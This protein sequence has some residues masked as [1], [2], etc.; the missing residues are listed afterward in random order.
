MDS[1]QII[2]N[3]KFRAAD[4]A[5]GDARQ[6]SNFDASK[7]EQILLQNRGFKTKN[8]Q[9]EFLNPDLSKITTKSLGIDKKAIEKTL[10]RIKEAI[11][12][13][14]QI[15]IYGDYDVDG[16]CATA[17][18]WETLRGVSANVMPY[19]PHRVKHGYGLT[20]KGISDMLLRFPNTKLLFTVDNGIVAYE[21]SKYAKEKAID[22]VITDH[23]L[24]SSE[25]PDVF[26]IVH[27]TQVCGTGVAYFLAQGIK[28]K[29]G[30]TKRDDHLELVALATVAD[31][32]PLVGPNRA[33][34]KEGLIEIH[35][36]KRVGLLE[37]FEE[38]Q[39]KKEEIGTYE[40]GHIIAPRINAMGRIGDAMD[41]LRLICTNNRERAR[42]LAKVLG[43]TNTDRQKLTFD[44]VIHA[45]EQFDR[46]T[47]KKLIFISHETYEEGIIGLVAGRLTE[48]FYR[49]AIVI[50]KGKL[51]S[52]A[53]ARSV[54]GFN[55]IEF[56]RESSEYLINAGGHPGAAGFS[57]ET[58]NLAKLQKKLEE[59][60]Q[61]VID[62]SLLIK[63]RRVDFELSLDLVG[64]KVY[65]IIEKF[66]PFGMGNPQPTF[67]AKKV[68]VENFKTV[69]ADG[70]H[71]K[72][73]LKTSSS[74]KALADK[75]NSKIYAIA[76]GMGEWGLKLKQGDEVDIVYTIE[77]NIWNGNVRY[78]IKLKNLEVSQ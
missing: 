77:Q 14:E 44:T 30:F 32:M 29:F 73:G 7:F 11:E 6:I 71:L 67:L 27:T 78:E 65:K 24:P 39:I 59:L 48:E 68:V 52:K 61:K 28:K 20:V 58:K 38:S 56:I 76:F 47:K 55:I 70:K 74:A 1:L 42:D 46:T 15:I 23:H 43:L 12:N 54:R 66:A 49:P 33:L 21:G 25:F 22:V 57:F 17:I 50:S 63:K 5:S 26:S 45:R 31:L 3:F 16:I 75:Q 62:D 37:I 40:I 72:L 9:E 18:L 53:S 35:S 36:T 34:L 60:A 2:S 8:Q 13:K 19:I 10:T 69:G 64:E 51:I 4:K 41:S